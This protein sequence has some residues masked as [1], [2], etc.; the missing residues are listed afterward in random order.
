MFGRRQLL[1]IGNYNPFISA[2][3]FS[4]IVS[5]WLNFQS[6]IGRRALAGR[7]LAQENGSNG[8][9]IDVAHI[10]TECSNGLESFL[11]SLKLEDILSIM[12]TGV[13]ASDNFST[14]VITE[15]NY[16]LLMTHI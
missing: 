2:W 4:V 12:N 9:T 3:G 8:L 13:C 1:Y 6:F 5:N 16:N 14:C 15:E 7:L 10:A 11:C